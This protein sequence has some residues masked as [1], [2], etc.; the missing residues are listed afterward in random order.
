MNDAAEQI[1]NEGRRSEKLADIRSL[2]ANMQLTAEQAMAAL[3]VPEKER[4]KYKRM[5]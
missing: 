2:M 5:L 4:T 3:G 1:R